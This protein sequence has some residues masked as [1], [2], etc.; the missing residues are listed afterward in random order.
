M[1][2]AD[3]PSPPPNKKRKRT[4]NTYDEFIQII[5]KLGKQY[6][7]ELFACLEFDTYGVGTGVTCNICCADK[8]LK[9]PFTQRTPMASFNFSSFKNHVINTTKHINRMDDDLIAIHPTAKAKKSTSDQPIISASKDLLSDLDKIHFAIKLIHF[10]IK[11]GLPDNKVSKINK[12]ID[13]N[14]KGAINTEIS[15]IWHY[16]KILNAMNIHQINCDD[17]D[18]LGPRRDGKIALAFDGSTHKHRDMKIFFGKGWKTGH[19]SVTKYVDGVDAQKSI[20]DLDV[21]LRDLL[22]IDTG[23]DNVKFIENVVNKR[24][25]IKWEQVIQ[26]A[27]DGA[28]NNTGINKGCATTVSATTLRSPPMAIFFCVTKISMFFCVTKISIFF[29]ATKISIFFVSQIFVTSLPRFVFFCVTKICYCSLKISI[30]LCHKKVLDYCNYIYLD[31]R[32]K[33]SIDGH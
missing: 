17:N 10:Q 9:G 14:C 3:I 31:Q 27:V 33:E 13:T 15:T 1:S 30:F 12:F 11:E 21:N 16:D 19:G 25:K 4:W 7:S 5:T 20:H 18:L 23:A 32:Y 28:S 24:L 22:T 8:K 6:P 26:L 2:N 29:C